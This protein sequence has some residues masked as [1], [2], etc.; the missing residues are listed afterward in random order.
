MAIIPQLYLLKRSLNSIRSADQSTISFN[1]PSFD[2]QCVTMMGKD[3]RLEDMKAVHIDL[4][5][6]IEGRMDRLLWGEFQLG[7]DVVIQD[8]PRCLDPYY[9]FANDLRNPWCASDGVVL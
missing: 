5:D 4:L 3:I 6:D 9:S 2:G 1:S 8:D 7:E